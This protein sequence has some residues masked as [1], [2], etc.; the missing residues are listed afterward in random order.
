M[1]RMHPAAPLV[2]THTNRKHPAAP[3]L[4]THTTPMLPATPLVCTN[5]THPTTPPDQAP[6]H[7]AAAVGRDD[8]P[9]AQMDPGAQLHATAG[10]A[11]PVR[12]A[13]AM[14]PRG[15]RPH[16]GAGLREHACVAAVTAQTCHR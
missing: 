7:G 16:R 10:G 11:S 2:C 3:L 4:C 8:N 15:M 6:G 13:R 9:R 1:H 12:P 5:R 14:Y